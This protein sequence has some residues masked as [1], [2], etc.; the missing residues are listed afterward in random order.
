MKVSMGNLQQS[1]AALVKISNTQLPITVAFK[2]TFL[3]KSIQ[4]S[5]ESFDAVKSKLLKEVGEVHPEKPDEYKIIDVD[6]WNKE[7]TALMSQE[8]DVP[9]DKIKV[10]QFGDIVVEP[11]T[12]FALDWLIESDDQ[13]S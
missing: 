1:L 13:Q 9:I 3:L 6:R 4:P 11:S 12:L 10:S 2:I 7:M 5:L 8:T